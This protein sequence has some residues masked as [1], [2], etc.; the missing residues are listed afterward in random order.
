MATHQRSNSDTF[1]AL[2]RHESYYLI[3]GDLF[4]LAEHIHFRVH[5]YFFERESPFFQRQL[6]VPASP[7]AVAR[8]STEGTAIIL[9]E[10]PDDFA[11][12][13]WVFYNPRYSLYKTTVDDWK[14]ILHLAHKWEFAE[15]KK[16]VVRELEKLRMSDVDRIA[17]YQKHEV[18]K[19]Y[20][21][22]RYA[23]LC[24][25]EQ[26]LTLEEGMQLGMETTLMIARAREYARSNPSADGSRSP[27][28]ASIREDEMHSL[29]RLLFE[30]RPPAEANDDNANSTANGTG[31]GID[32]GTPAGG[33]A[34]AAPSK[35][36]A[37]VI[38]P[39]TPDKPTARPMTTQTGKP[40]G[41]PVPWPMAPQGK[42]EK[43]QETTGSKGKG[44]GKGKGKPVPP[45]PL[46]MTA[47]ATVHPA[48]P[49]V[50]V[51]TQTEEKAR[52]ERKTA[53]EPLIDLGEPTNSATKDI[54]VSGSADETQETKDVVDRS[55]DETQRAKDVVNGMLGDAK[56]DDPVQHGEA[57]KTEESGK[58]DELTNPVDTVQTGEADE[59]KKAGEVANGW[60]KV[61]DA[62]DS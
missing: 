49:S 23:A 34:A 35:E 30:I 52:E 40:T 31:S 19:N 36:P 41:K 45:T 61:N 2:S 60:E 7:G 51:E 44:K 32:S 1:R 42:A 21:I 18:D 27:T 20:L 8:G 14:V 25:R 16:L 48:P 3:G 15:V 58:T 17:T 33:L 57:G 12:F 46:V 54:T 38:P 11:K 37:V 47:T 29:V 4:F 9:E 5:R 39:A 6:Q 13:L 56:F 62:G 22:P 43:E 55:A 24:E 10:R 50:A 59:A 26:P 53:P 28:T